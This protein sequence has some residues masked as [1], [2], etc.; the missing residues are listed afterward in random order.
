M[1][2]VNYYLTAVPVHKLTTLSQLQAMVDYCVKTKK[3]MIL[4]F[5]GIDKKDSE[6]YTEPFCWLEDD[7]VSLCEYIKSLQDEGKLEVKNPIEMFM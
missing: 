1:K 5:H 7:F 2:T 4:E 3:W 6:E